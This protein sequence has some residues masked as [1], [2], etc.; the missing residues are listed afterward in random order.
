MKGKTISK[1]VSGTLLF[2][3][4]S[5]ATVPVFA[6]TKDE[7]VYSKM[8]NT[9]KNYKTVVSTHLE[10]T[11]D[12]DTLEDLSDLVNIKNT[13]GDET[14]TQ[15]GHKFVW[16]ADKNDIYYQGDTTK[17]LPVELNIKYEL[18][19][20]EISADEIAG[21]S[22]KV[23]I[24]LD[25]T[26]KEQ[27]TVT[28]NG[29]QETMYVPFVIVAG[30]I[31]NNDN[32]K[33]VTVSSGKVIDD[34][35]RAIVAGVAMPGLQESLGISKDDVDIPSSIEIEMDATNFETSSIV[36]YVTPKVFDADDVKAFD[37]LDEVYNDVNT[38]Q[39]SMNQIQDGA[40]QLDDGTHQL[41]SALDTEINKYYELRN[42]YSKKDAINKIQSI[43]N[44]KVNEMLPDLQAKA[45]QE[46]Q[47][48][49]KNHQDELVNS[50]ISTAVAYTNKA[51]SDKIAQIANGADLL[52]AEQKQAL[53]QTLQKDLENAM[54]NVNSNPENQQ[55]LAVIKASMKEEAKKTVDSKLTEMSGKADTS[56]YT[57]EATELVQTYAKIYG[58]ENA[59]KVAAGTMTQAQAQADAMQRAQTKAT[60]IIFSVSAKTL[61]SAKT[62]VDA[63]IDNAIMS[64]TEQK[65]QTEINTYVTSVKQDLAKQLASQVGNNPEVI[66]NITNSFK[67]QILDSVRKELVNDPN[68]QTMIKSASE[69]DIAEISQK[70]ASD[71]A[72]KYTVTLANEVSDNLIKS[73][74]NADN[75]NSM[76]NQELG[77]YESQI[78]NALNKADS[79]MTELQDALNQLTDGSSQLSDGIKTFN[80]EGIHKISDLVNGEV[81]DLDERLQKLQDL[82]KEYNTFTMVDGEN[83]AETK[84]IM[85]V[86]AVKKQEES[87][88]D[89]E[90]AVVNDTNE[91]VNE[92]EIK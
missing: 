60:Q 45:Q 42:Q 23:K 67:A 17:E 39:D 79:S 4:V 61:N 25:Y 70:T 69:K 10:N 41:Q 87:E 30:T 78:N 91:T 32:A 43:V 68:L 29:K 82:S 62:Q 89:K 80:D 19:G 73:E 58:E 72:N 34:G 24:T 88:Q 92:E 47:T 5:Y 49:V 1:I 63:A 38:L 11:D 36:N 48:V 15:D 9:G 65:L 35:T 84:F 54:A 51:T 33:N 31:I 90:Q 71:L 44:Q 21:K 20:K 53:Q 81:K 18:D 85:V 26:N 16:K 2:S 12:L 13:S 77:K 74:L 22:G 40:E 55:L 6:Y 3:M 7:T 75:A 56:I 28:I 46:A 83:E 86:D 37:K 27:R 14:F 8:D 50:T 59:A 64:G 52:T 57:Q 76:I 66:N